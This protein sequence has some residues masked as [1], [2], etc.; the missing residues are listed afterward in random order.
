MT[1][2]PEADVPVHPTGVEP[3]PPIAIAA[4]DTERLTLHLPRL[5]DFEESFATR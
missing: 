1:C 5:E 2:L 3:V 4:I